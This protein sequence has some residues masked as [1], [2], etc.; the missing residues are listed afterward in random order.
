MAV[1]LRC[2]STTIKYLLFFF[3]FLFTLCGLAILVV[4]VICTGVLKGENVGALKGSVIFIIVVGATVFII[5]FF[6]CCGAVRESH[7]MLTVFS[8]FLMIL[9]VCQVIAAVLLFVN[10]NGIND[11]VG[12]IFKSALNGNND[13]IIVTDE[14]QKNFQ[15]CGATDPSN[16]KT[17]PVSCCAEGA[18]TCTLANAYSKGCVSEVSWYVKQYGKALGAVA[19]VVALV[20]I[21]GVWFALALA[22]EIKKLSR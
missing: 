8:I 5:A 20:E 9:I 13:A 3:N 10:V 22:A 12:E 4:G 1:G 2:G 17:I 19:I 18:A 16:W 15:C 6:G 7:F 14:I 21:I 11:A